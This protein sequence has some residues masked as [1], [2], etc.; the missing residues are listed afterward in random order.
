V[1]FQ[2]KEKTQVLMALKASLLFLSTDQMV[3]GFTMYQEMFGNGLVI[4]I[5]LI[6]TKLSLNKE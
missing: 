2:L 6:I 4:G 5:V 1:N 3:M